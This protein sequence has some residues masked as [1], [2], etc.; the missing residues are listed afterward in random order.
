MWGPTANSFAL[1]WNIGSRLHYKPKL[2]YIFSKIVHNRTIL[3][4]FEIFHEFDFMTI[5]C[6][7]LRPKHYQDE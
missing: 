4:E 2:K 3:Y 5:V 6:I 7:N 1:Q